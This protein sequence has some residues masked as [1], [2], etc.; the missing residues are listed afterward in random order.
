MSKLVEEMKAEMMEFQ[1]RQKEI[2]DFCKQQDEEFEAWKESVLSFEQFKLNSDD[3]LDGDNW[4]CDGEC[5]WTSEDEM[6]DQQY[7]EQSCEECQ[8]AELDG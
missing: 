3:N 6:D 8:Q 5:I 2:Q 4:I 1:R 7:H